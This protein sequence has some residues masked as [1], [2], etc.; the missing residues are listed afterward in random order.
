M[1]TR[2]VNPPFPAKPAVKGFGALR[3]AN[4]SAHR[5]LAHLAINSVG[6]VKL[7]VSQISA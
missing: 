3:E 4:A 2:D 1:L 7:S 5:E 6:F